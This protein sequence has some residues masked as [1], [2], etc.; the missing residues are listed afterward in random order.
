MTI[1]SKLKLSDKTRSSMHLSPEERRRAKMLESIELQIKAAEA[2]VEGKIYMLVKQKYVTDTATGERVKREVKVPVKPWWWSDVSGTVYLTP[3]YG[4]RK[5]ELTKGNQSIEVGVKGKLASALKT[6]AE[7]VK[8][9][10]LDAAMAH[11]KN[12]DKY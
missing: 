4:N 9:G 3:R 8:K 1:L 5:L 2:E 7:A 12:T 6:L 11:G 10:E